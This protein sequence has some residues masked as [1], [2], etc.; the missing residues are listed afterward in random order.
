LKNKLKFGTGGVPITAKSR[1]T[2]AGINRIAELGL[3]HMELEFVY[4]V[5]MSETFALECKQEAINNKISLSVHAPY[6]INLASDENKTL[7]GSIKHITDSIYIGGLAGAKSV[8]FHPGF[9]QG[10]DK[11]LVLTKVIKAFEKIYLE[12]EKEKYQH[13]PYA[14]GEIILAP[15]LTGKPT[16]V[17]D[18]EELIEISKSFEHKKQKLCIDF[19]HKYARSNGAYNTEKEFREIF[20]KIEKN[21]GSSY[22]DDLHIH[23]S[24][25]LYSPKGEKNHVTML[26]TWQEYLNNGIDTEKGDAIMQKLAL[27][28]RTEISNF[29]WKTLLKVAKDMNVGG[30]VVCESPNLEIDALLMKGFYDNL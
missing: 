8:T 11:Q 30:F 17:G 27:K 29:D 26:P 28:G 20:E 6:Y 23:V 16:Q 10:K 24:A 7:Y 15:E 5:K 9:Y 18:I 22:L 12:L 2:N 4:G 14:L 25:I 19:A 13:H 1:D 3:D 21:L